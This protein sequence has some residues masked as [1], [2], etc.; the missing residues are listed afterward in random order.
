MNIDGLEQK[1]LWIKRVVLVKRHQ[2]KQKKNRGVHSESRGGR[3]EAQW[4][5]FFVKSSMEKGIFSIS[6]TLS[7]IDCLKD[8]FRIASIFS[9]L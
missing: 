5:N 2:K 8:L 3:V 7:F 4:R 1:K 9:H 6:I